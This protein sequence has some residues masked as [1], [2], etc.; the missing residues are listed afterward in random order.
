MKFQRAVML[1]LMAAG[2]LAAGA[3]AGCSGFGKNQQTAASD[4]NVFPANYR[5]TLVT[6]LRQSL[7][8][9]DDFHG[10]MI[11][12]PALRPV[13]QSQH[14]IVCV[15]FNSAQRHQDDY[16]RSLSFPTDDAIH[17]RHSGAMRGRGLPAVQGA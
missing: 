5:S 4:P 16:G 13:G 12:E 6:F 8:N 11:S 10:A 2:V 7:T 1:L 15:Q 3:L 9:R 14:Y 17:R